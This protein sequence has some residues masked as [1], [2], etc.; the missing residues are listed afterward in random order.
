MLRLVGKILVDQE[1]PMHPL[2]ALLEKRGLI[3]LQIAFDSL[4]GMSVVP[5]AAGN[6]AIDVVQGDA[7]TQLRI[8]HRHLPV[9]ADPGLAA[10]C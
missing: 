10:W 5:A 9:P 3:E 2:E 8:A 7:R 6:D 1:I 4:E